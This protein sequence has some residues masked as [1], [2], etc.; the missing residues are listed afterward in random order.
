MV[1]IWGYL[2]VARGDKQHLMFLCL[3]GILGISFDL[4][5][6]FRGV[7]EVLQATSHHEIEQ[8]SCG[9]WVFLTENLGLC[10]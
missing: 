4:L 5:S 6:T 7:A 8:G 10:K 9:N 3:Q 1:S 2:P